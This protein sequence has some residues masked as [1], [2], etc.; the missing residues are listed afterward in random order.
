M[1]IPAS[2]QAAGRE[3]LAAAARAKE[4]SLIC[5]PRKEGNQREMKEKRFT[6]ACGADGRTHL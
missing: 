3:N 4:A 2:A 1:G 5:P 6:P